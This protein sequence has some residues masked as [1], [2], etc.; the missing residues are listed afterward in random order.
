MQLKWLENN[1]NRQIEIETSFE[2]LK[3]PQLE[4]VRKQNYVLKIFLEAAAAAFFC[5][6]W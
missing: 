5:W 4:C 1:Y 6:F 3:Q 2:K